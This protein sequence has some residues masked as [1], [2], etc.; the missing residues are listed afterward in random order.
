MPLVV[1]H[2]CSLTAVL[3]DADAMAYR[4]AKMSSIVNLPVEITEIS[5]WTS[6]NPVTWEHTMTDEAAQADAFQ[7]MLTTY[8]SHPNVTSSLLWGFGECLVRGLKG[9]G[10]DA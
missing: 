4:I 7:K 8:F 3:I 10:K 9:A 2:C 1:D 5:F 6:E